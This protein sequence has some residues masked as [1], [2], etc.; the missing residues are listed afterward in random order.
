[1]ILQGTRIGLSQASRGVDDT[2][3]DI[4]HRASPSLTAQVAVDER[5]HGERPRHLHTDTARQD[6]DGTR[7]GGHDGL[8]ET[9]LPLG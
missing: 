1:M 3:E 2:G 4:Q 9:I 7:I 5:G 6:D 8:D